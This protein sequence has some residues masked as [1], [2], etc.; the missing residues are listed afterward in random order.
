MKENSRAVVQPP[1]LRDQV[2]NLL[3]EDLIAEAFK[4]GQRLVELELAKR[5]NVSRTP[6]REAMAR[7]HRE[8]LLTSNERGYQVP[9]DTQRD[10]VDRLEVRRLLDAQVARRAARLCT[11]KQIEK[12]EKLYNSECQA[13]EQNNHK[14]FIEHHNAFREQIRSFSDNSLLIRCAEIVDDTF[15]LARNQIHENSDNR[16]KSLRC[17]NELLEAI[18]ASDEQAAA[19]AIERFI[20]SL[21]QFFNAKESPN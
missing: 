3:K 21:L 1:K 4:P 19:G 14:K 12:L 13:H 20:D 9:L 5:Y 11:P 17:D 18:K 10:I 8:D 16:Q 6:V 15:Q 7:L 2:Y